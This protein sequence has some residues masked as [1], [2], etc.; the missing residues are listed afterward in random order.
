VAET[1]VCGKCGTE[2]APDAPA[3]LCPKCL[4]Q[5]SLT[6]E[7]G[8][9]EHSAPS[10]QLSP[11]ERAAATIPPRPRAATPYMEKLAGQFQHLDI[12][13]HLGQGGMG[14]VYKARQR[15]LNRIVAVKVLPPTVGEDPAFAGRFMLEAQALAQLNHP[16]IVQVYDFGRTEEFFYFMMEYVDGANL[17][18][19]MRDGT[20]TPQKTLR[21]VPQICR[22]LQFAHDEGIVHRDIKPENIL[23]DKKERVKIADFGLA[24]LLGRT[25]E[26]LSLTGTG[27]LMGTL[28]YM[29]PE[30]LREAHRVD[31]RADIYSLGVVFYEM[32]TGKLP[33]G[34][35]DPPSQLA[36]V[37]VRLDQIVL[38][39][40]ES[41]PDRRYQHAGEIGEQVDRFTHAEAPTTNEHPGTIAAALVS[42]EG[43]HW[44][45]KFRSVDPRVGRQL[46]RIMA[47]ILITGAGLLFVMS[48]FKVIKFQ[49]AIFAAVAC[50]LLARLVKR[51]GNQLFTVDPESLIAA[52]SKLQAALA[53]SAGPRRDQTLI[54]L[55]R[56]AARG[57]E[58]AVSQ[59]ALRSI[60]DDKM[61]DSNA[62]AC[63]EQIAKKE[64]TEAALPIARMIQD[65]ARRDEV[66]HKLAE[67]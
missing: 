17:R 50:S 54:K 43:L 5:G 10:A 12:L 35:F 61:R 8:H 63:A 30:Q 65:S 28:G 37:D 2:L 62:V 38:R 18:A 42:H 7:T 64:G 22:A 51:I 29:A 27:Q 9:D 15:H 36:P 19:L 48:P 44:I 60:Q 23:V 59:L 47:T 34:R 31:H 14:V 46:V 16:N 55:A 40:L 49:Y 33:I 67:M 26:E 6:R 13:E 21:I 39:S 57:G 25:A 52:N 32:L 3:A 4:M 20:L 11:G 24:K 45:D 1:K 56:E 66:L 53:M 58:G 41:D